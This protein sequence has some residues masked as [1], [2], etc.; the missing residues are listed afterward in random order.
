M[1]FASHARLVLACASTLA[2]ALAGCNR[3]MVRIPTN[4]SFPRTL[5][6]YEAQHP[7]AHSLQLAA[8]LDVRWQHHGE[9]VAGTGW[10]ACKTDALGGDE[11]SRIVADRLAQELSFSKLFSGVG[12]NAP[13]DL[14]LKTQIHA[15]CAQ[16]FGFIYLRVAG[17]TALRFQLLRGDEVVYDRKIERVVTDADDEYSGGQFT[18][19]ESAMVHVMADSLRE[20]MKEL[21]SDLDARSATWAAEK[22]RS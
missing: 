17:L 1:S 12:S 10:K 2:L 3:A 9:P 7:S 14:Q 21:M 8:P 19:I 4:A 20:V 22:P 13:G 16:V 6:G 15:F 18:M 11:A 5:T